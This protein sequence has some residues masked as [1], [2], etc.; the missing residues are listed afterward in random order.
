[1]QH[2]F[3]NGKNM[4]KR[5]LLLVLF[6]FTELS[7]EPCDFSRLLCKLLISVRKLNHDIGEVCETKK[8][9]KKS[10]NSDN[11]ACFVVDLIQINN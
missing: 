3:L 1:M 7:P 2:P 6:P 11:G 5:V 10:K 8:C 4:F 9:W